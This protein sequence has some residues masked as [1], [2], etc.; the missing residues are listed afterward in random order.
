MYVYIYI[1]IYIYI[2]VCVCLYINIYIY[3]YIYIRISLYIYT[4]VY[5]TVVAC[6]P[7]ILGS[8]AGTSLSED[9]HPCHQGFDFRHGGRGCRDNM[10]RHS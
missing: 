7:M 1:Y 6:C 8:F 10:Y 4:I 9:N 5:T 2:C 3:I